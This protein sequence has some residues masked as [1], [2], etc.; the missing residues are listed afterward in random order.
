MYISRG[1]L[2]FHSQHQHAHPAQTGSLVLAHSTHPKGKENA[3]KEHH[4]PNEEA[5]V[6]GVD[7][8]LSLMG[9]GSQLL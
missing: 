7:S 2:S 9:G 1:K 8:P 5:E 3:N 4:S 6:L